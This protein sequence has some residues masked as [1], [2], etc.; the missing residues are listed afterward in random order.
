MK[1][2]L[3][4]FLFSMYGLFYLVDGSSPNREQ[5]PSRLQRRYVTRFSIDNL[6]KVVLEGKCSSNIGHITC[7]PTNY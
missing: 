6:C 5:V 4:Q 3:F 7:T 1:D 2:N